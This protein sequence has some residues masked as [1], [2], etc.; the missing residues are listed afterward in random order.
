VSCGPADGLCPRSCGAA[1]ADPDCPAACLNGAVSS[2]C[3][4]AGSEIGAGFCCAGAGAP[5]IP[6][7]LPAA[8]H[9]VVEGTTVVDTQTGVAIV[10]NIPRNTPIAF[11]Y[12][13]NLVTA[14]NGGGYLLAAG[15]ESPSFRDHDL[16]GSIIAGNRLTWTGA[17][18]TA[19]THA[20]FVGYGVNHRIQYNFLES[21]PYGIVTKSSG[22]TFTSG[23]VAYNVITNPVQG[24]CAKGING[25]KFY[26]NTFYDARSTGVTALL[27]IYPN[28]DAG[29]PGFPSTNAQ[30]YNNV[31]YTKFQV[32]HIMLSASS[33]PGFLSD[34]NVFYSE[35]GSPQF[36][37]EGV[38]TLDFAGWQA[39]GYDAHSVVVDPRFV[40]TETLIPSAP[41]EYGKDLG[42]EWRLGLSP[43]T[44]WGAEPIVAPQGAKW[45][46]GAYVL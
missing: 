9:L 6:S 25:V 38:G 5:P 7:S 15:G 20:L 12:R 3:R 46:V 1:A 14:Q 10:V 31:F 22:M 41:L 26:N 23:G 17:D 16:D 39:L 21:T 13:N 28:T 29:S 30:V 2:L 18:P 43:A 42:A 27:R 40:D 32:P 19:I 24:A 4:C 33:R 34:Y 37:V 11:E 44:V 35:S 8:S 45:Q 36:V